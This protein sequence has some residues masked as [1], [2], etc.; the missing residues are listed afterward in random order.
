MAVQEAYKNDSILI[1]CVFEVHQAVYQAHAVF[2]QGRGV[3]GG[4]V[5]LMSRSLI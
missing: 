4:W 3:S 2:G 1:M 5:I